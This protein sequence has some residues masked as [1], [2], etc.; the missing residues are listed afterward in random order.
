MNQSINN[1]SDRDTH[2]WYSHPY[3]WMV[4]AFPLAAVIAGFITLT[5]A[6][7]S[8]TGLVVD[9]Y[10]RKGLAINQIIER[11]QYAASHQIQALV[12]YDPTSQRLEVTVSGEKDGIEDIY[13]EFLRATQ[14]GLDHRVALR[15]SD[16]GGYEGFMAAL[17]P[18]VW[19]IQIGTS[20]WRLTD[21]SWLPDGF[22]LS[23]TALPAQ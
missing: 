15:Q 13:I 20:R 10:Y 12:N 16:T 17:P 6:I 11:D 19:N 5:L 23:L 1:P 4:I 7:Q 18:G 8:D 21:R 22:P 14:Q 3:V 9:D 2:P